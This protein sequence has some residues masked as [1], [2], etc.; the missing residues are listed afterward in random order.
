MDLDLKPQATGDAL[1]HSVPVIEIS[2]LVADPSSTSAVQAIDAI[3]RACEEW[4]F[5]QVT[6]HGIPA[7]RINHVW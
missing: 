4:G 5:F 6:G 1:A 7:Q 3:A 2:G